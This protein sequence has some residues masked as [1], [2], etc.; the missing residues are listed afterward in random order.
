[1]PRAMNEFKV[2]LAQRTIIRAL[3]MATTT[4]GPA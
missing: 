1:V 4:G 3:E 2:E